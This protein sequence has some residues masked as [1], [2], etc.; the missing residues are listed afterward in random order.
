MKLNWVLG[1]VLLLVSASAVL[2]V[3]IAPQLSLTPDTTSTSSTATLTAIANDP[4]TSP[5]IR[6]IVSIVL[7]KDGVQEATSSC[8]G[9]SSTCVL[10]EVE[11]TPNAS[12][13]EYYSEAIDNEGNKVTSS[14]VTITYTGTNVPPNITGLPNVSIAEDSG[15]SLALIDLHLFTTD[16]ETLVPDLTYS[17]I[18]ESNLSVADCEISLNQNVDCTTVTGNL[19]GNSAVVVQ[20][21]DGYDV[22]NDTII[23]T[24]TPVNDPLQINQS[25]ILPNITFAED[26]SSTFDLQGAF[27]DVDNSTFIYTFSTNSSMITTNVN[28][29]LVTLV[30][31]PNINGNLSLLV[32]GSDGSFT[33]SLPVIIVNITPVD[34]APVFI[35]PISNITFPEDTSIQLTGTKSNWNEVDGQQINISV[36]GNVL[37]NIIINNTADEI[38]I[39]PP[40]N[41]TGTETVIFNATDGVLSTLSNP[42]VINVTNVNDP[43][44]FNASMPIMNITMLEDTVNTSINVS[45]H[46]YDIDGD[47]LVWDFD[48]DGP[49]DAEINQTTGV[50]NIIAMTNLNGN[51]TLTFTATDGNLTSQSSNIVYV[52]VLPVNDAPVFSPAIAN[53]TTG[54]NQTLVYDIDATD[55]EGDNITYSDNVS[56]INSSTGIFTITPTAEGNFS[57]TVNACDLQDCTQGI[58]TVFVGPPVSII[59]NSSFN[60][61][62]YNGLFSNLTGVVTSFVSHSNVYLDWQINDSNLTRVFLNNTFIR[63][64]N[65]TDSN[66][67]NS[68]LTNCEI[69]NST[70]KNY[71]GTDCIITNSIVDPPTGLNNLTGSNITGNSNITNSDV[72]FSNVDNSSILNSTMTNS[73]ITDGDI[74]TSINTNTVIASTSERNST[75]TDSTVNN[76]FIIRDTVSGSSI[77]DTTISDS[78]VVNS[79][80]V[81]SVMIWS[82]ISKSSIYNSSMNFVDISDANIT[83][84]VIYN[85]TIIF[86]ATFYNASLSGPANLTDL[87]NYAPLTSFTVNPSS[88][89]TGVAINFTSTTTDLNIPGSLN[90]VLTFLWDFGD[91]TNSTNVSVLKSY[92]ASGTYDIK[93]Y[94]TDIYGAIGA[95]PSTSVT[96]NA[97][98]SGGGGSGGS[99]G[100]SGGS[101]GSR[102]SDGPGYN[103][104][105]FSNTTNV[106]VI[107]FT[108]LFPD[109]ADADSDDTDDSDAGDSDTD[110]DDSDDS[111]VVEV[112]EEGKP[113]M[114]IG[115]TIIL[116][117]LVFGLLIFGVVRKIVL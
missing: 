35:G 78:S 45:Q 54:A 99:G 2:A 113:N 73:T 100:G 65:A 109:D 70:V 97:P 56:A 34:D 50:V 8:S 55:V 15:W 4:D 117:I 10:V 90:D 26:G 21:S 25:F 27:I 29:T 33:E 76:S 31:Q 67:I 37:L 16:F 7:Y 5:D 75:V 13:H 88:A 111:N 83:S 1:L 80:I 18:S 36:S 64:S 17:I 102:S 96:I 81:D 9:I 84:G 53:Q 98:S 12:V 106:T 86:N 30:G 112:T 32:S 87:V 116:G 42:V 108:D 82:N 101:G 24:V 19:T 51:G 89:N 72:L 94:A 58:F 59:T 69:I 103:L 71:I 40:A 74:V 57:V 23:V 20:V 105:D 60:G 14:T 52:E 115:F 85:G 28:G 44:M 47:N 38:T 104:T 93:L 79:T 91:G 110:A 107:D 39:V 66:L 3:D 49:I 48:D 61:T 6:D 68:D 46:F 77:T 63:N 43:P 41:F 62:L 11:Y 114:G 95:L 22:D 92:G